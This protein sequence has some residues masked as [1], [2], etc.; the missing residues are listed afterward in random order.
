MWKGGP[1]QIKAYDINNIFYF[2]ETEEY[3][4]VVEYASQLGYIKCLKWAIQE[5][6]AE[7]GQALIYASA[8][9]NIECVKFLLSHGCDP[10]VTNTIGET[11]LHVT[12]NDE[13]VLLLLNAGALYTQTRKG[14]TA[15]DYSYYYMIDNNTVNI[16][17]Q[18]VCTHVL[19]S[20][21][22][23]NSTALHAPQWL[24]DFQEDVNIQEKNVAFASIA[25]YHV[26]KHTKLFDKE[27][28][29]YFIC[30]YILQTKGNTRWLIRTRSKFKKW[31]RK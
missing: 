30:N 15:L 20:G 3:Q 27:F 1:L 28:I 16:P 31:I 18:V 19:N 8:Y 12:Q 4:R 10:N 7:F 24:L 11:G 17:N 5:M 23:I 9:N 22:Q 29:H 13:I 2:D 21:D 26:L 25:M 6:H 14:L